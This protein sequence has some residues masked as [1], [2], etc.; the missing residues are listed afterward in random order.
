[1]TNLN[2]KV[3]IIVLTYN[4]KNNL[5]DCFFSLSKISYPQ[6]LW[7]VL[8]MDNRST[9]GTVEQIK[10]DY[11][12]VKVI[13]NDQNYGFAKG[14]NLGMQWALE[15]D[16]DY[17]YLL[18]DDTE[19]D[20]DF[21]TKAVEQAEANEQ[22]GSVGSRLM[23]WNDKELINSIGNAIH[24][25]GFGYCNGYKE[26]FD[27]QKHY[28]KQITYA[29][30]AGVL[31][32]KQVLEKVGLLD[33]NFF[34]YHEDLDL[35]WR[36][37]LAGYKNILAK[38]SIVYH[39]YSFSKSIQKYYYM[40]RNRFLVLL[41]N[42]K[43]ASLVLIFPAWLIMEIGLFAFSFKSGWWKEKLRVYKYFFKPGVWGKIIDKRDKVRQFRKVK[44]K[45]IIKHF[46]GKI[47]YQEQE[48]QN[49]ILEKIAN[50]VF[51]AYFWVVKKIIFW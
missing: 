20:P 22:V 4:S 39:K 37:S 50:P 47:S 1:M 5:H 51:N 26:K 45:E 3:C 18:N 10:Q 42:L 23:L 15:N 33:E 24:Y 30:G 6:E 49:F 16:F 25:L 13:V 36:I 34:M 31:L 46:V 14:N 38:D 7:T 21:L 32:K 41:Y 27:P 44:D 29:S 11:P 43:F 12:W 19:V 8:V 2:K 35:A 28:K 40:E 9:D 48:M 17:I